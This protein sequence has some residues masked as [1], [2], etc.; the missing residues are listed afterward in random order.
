MSEAPDAPFFL[1]RSLGGAVETP[2][3]GAASAKVYDGPD[4]TLVVLALAPGAE[5]GEHTSRRPVALYVFEGAGRASVGE[6]EVGLLPGTWLRV[7]P[8]AVHAV[9][10]TS[11]M[12]L[13]LMLVKAQG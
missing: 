13:A 3:Q 11:A 7:E 1:A 10:A 12:K 8:G 6:A 2:E 4:L 9:K 5:L